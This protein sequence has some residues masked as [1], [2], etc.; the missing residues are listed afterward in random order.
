M[1]AIPEQ[2]DSM[3]ITRE[4]Y[5]EGRRLWMQYARTFRALG[6]HV[7]AANALDVARDYHDKALRA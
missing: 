5:R 7:D 1:E 4:W 6:H 2:E 3:I